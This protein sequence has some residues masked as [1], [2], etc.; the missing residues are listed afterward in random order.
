MRTPGL[1]ALKIC[2]VACSSAWLRLVKESFVPI[3]ASLLDYF[4]VQRWQISY[5]AQG[6]IQF[7][8]FQSPLVNPRMFVAH[9]GN[10]KIRLQLSSHSA[11]QTFP[12]KP[13]EHKV[14]AH[15][16]CKLWQ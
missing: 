7:P 15:R 9:Q 3:I 13:S 2:M 8:L 11:N 12:G 4:S 5:Q 6:V 1:L 10:S 16:G 14:L